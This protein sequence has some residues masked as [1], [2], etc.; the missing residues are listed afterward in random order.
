MTTLAAVDRVVHHAVILDMG[1]VPS[2]RA[3]Q[4]QEQ[5]RQALEAVGSLSSATA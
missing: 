2:F 1:S 3:Q 5:Q 4:A